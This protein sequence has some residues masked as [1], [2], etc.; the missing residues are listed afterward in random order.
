M[1]KHSTNHT[2]ARATGHSSSPSRGTAFCLPLH[3]ERVRGI[4]TFTCF[5]SHIHTG[6][7]APHMH[8][9][10]ESPGPIFPQ[11]TLLHPSMRPKM[12][13]FPLAACNQTECYDSSKSAYSHLGP[14]AEVRVSPSSHK[15]EIKS[16][17]RTKLREHQTSLDSRSFSQIAVNTVN[18]CCPH[19]SSKRRTG[20][21]TA[22]KCILDYRSDNNKYKNVISE[23][24]LL[25]YEP[26]C[27][28]NNRAL[29]H[30]PHED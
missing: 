21:Q 16:A 26:L 20:V 23:M 2:L 17:M 29:L 6:A 14:F 30:Q 18:T 19:F 24:N 1:Q 3:R 25:R 5:T 22:T 7:A 4:N 28:R 8:P 10:H 15:H 27:I 11:M 13:S 9:K 12:D